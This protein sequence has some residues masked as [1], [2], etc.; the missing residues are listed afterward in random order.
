[1]VNGLSGVRTTEA[2]PAGKETWANRLLL[3][4]VAMSIAWMLISSTGIPKLGVFI[5]PK[6]VTRESRDRFG[7][8]R[9]SLPEMARK[10]TGKSRFGLVVVK[11]EI[12]WP[13]SVGVR[14][15]VV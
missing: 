3:S 4:P 11:P 9:P 15:I 6:T 7:R 2:A 14:V 13:S 5:W 10:G 12:H 8:F 1:M